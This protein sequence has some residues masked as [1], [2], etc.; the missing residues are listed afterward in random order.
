ME[1]HRLAQEK[2]RGGVFSNYRLR[3]ATVSRDYGMEERDQAPLDS[4]DA[5]QIKEG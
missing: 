2:G 1:T 5:H 4:K 3:V